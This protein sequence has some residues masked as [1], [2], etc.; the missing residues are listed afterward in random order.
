MK[1]IAAVLVATFMALGLAACFLVPATPS[2][3]QSG[4]DMRDFCQ[5]V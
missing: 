3:W 1:K 2:D 5:W 4:S